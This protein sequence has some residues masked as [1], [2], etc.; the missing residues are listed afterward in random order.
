MTSNALTPALR[1]TLSLFEADGVPLTTNEVAERLDL[2]RRST[3]DRL[4]RLADR[5]Q[6]RT[7]KVGANARVWWQPVRSD[8]SHTDGSADGTDA[9]QGT[10]TT[11]TTELRRSERAQTRRDWQFRSLVEAT[12]EYAIF[13]LDADGHVQTWNEGARRI[14]GYDVDE[15]VGEHFSTFYADEAR[16][17]G[18]PESNL[19]AAAADGT[20][21]EEGW[22]VR[23]DG[24]RF[25]ASVTI[26]ALFDDDGTLD[27][28]AKVTRDMTERREAERELRQEKAFV[29]SLFD[30]QRDVLYAFDTDGKFLRWNDRFETVTDCDPAQ[31]RDG[32]P[33]DFVGDDAVADAMDAFERVVE[34]GETVTVELPLETEDGPV[35]YE[36]SA[37]PVT[38]D[39][40]DR[41]AGVTGI[42][43]DV[44]ERKR[45][46][47][48]IERQRDDLEAELQE[49]FERIDDAFFGLDEDWRFTHVSDRAA[50]LLNRSV[51]ELVGRRVW[52]EFPASADSTFRRKYEDAFETQD[53]VTFEEFYPPLD[54]WFEVSAYPSESGLSVYFRDITERKERERALERY[55]TIVETVEDGIYV[56]DEDGYFTEANEAYESLVGHSRERLLGSHVS[57]VI[58]DEGTLDAAREIEAELAAG[59]RSTASL[60]AELTTPDGDTRIGEATFALMDIESGYERVAVVR[61]VTER[62]ERE[63]DLERYEAIVETVGD[64]IYAVDDEGR[65]VLVN[66]GFCELTG[67]ERSELLGAHATRIHDD[68]ITPRAQEMADEVARGERDVGRL[69]LDVHTKSGDAVRCESRLSPFPMGDS[70]GRCGVTRDIS[71]RLEREREL[72]RQREQLAAL[73]NLN[74]VVRD[75]TDAVIERSTRDEIEAAVCERIAATDSYRFAWIGDAD[76]TAETITFRT[77]AGVDGYLDDVIISLDPDDERSDGPAGRAF[78]TGE[79]QTTRDV[80]TDPRFEPWRDNAAEHGVRS[81]AAV[82]IRHEETTY[83]VLNVYADR[84]DAFEETERAVLDQLGEIVGHAIAATER[85]RALMSDEI[86]ELQFRLPKVFESLDVPSTDAG[87]ISIEHA[88]PIR[89]SEYL[90]YG[91]VTADAVDSVRGLVETLPHWEDVTFREGDGEIGFEARFSEPPVL[92]TV[93]SLGGSVAQATIEDGTYDMTI[94]VPTSVDVR[95]VIDTVTE[96]YPGINLLKRRQRTRD[97]ETTTQVRHA[98]ETELTD[99]QLA[100]LQAAYYAGFFEWPR[101]ASGEDVAD[102]LGVAPPT[103][104]QHLRKAESKVFDRLLSTEL[105]APE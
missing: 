64:G 60:E 101:D 32:E 40:G 29:E 88:T 48:E 54:A 33:I 58:G 104:H 98:L 8:V 86:V 57:T 31:I 73:N 72:L 80:E 75:I 1:E 65:F 91:T 9:T 55:E 26:T 2:G 41:I 67:Y 42:G 34:R 56:V 79:I 78:R 77:G 102:S 17:A 14:K 11:D 25:W 96:A 95:Q 103:F 70:Y 20:Y 35:P 69:E 90:V 52:D 27:G 50:D 76:R 82:P 15:I 16:A 61:D 105:S 23:A 13:L 19:E 71:A 43:R 99:R 45:R 74:Y 68:E 18:N 21:Q 92:S 47:R 53:P 37:S 62:K 39:G 36:F 24:S 83:G 81:S 5:E 4:D 6:V 46:Q 66:D 94:Y 3:Y 89:D 63:R 7:K 30:N 44:S 85:K 49:V 97:T 59:E 51:G 87:R 93:A 84:P 38:E 10:E 28:Y 22:R 12:E 100:S